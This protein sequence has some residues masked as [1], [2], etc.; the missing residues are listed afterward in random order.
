MFGG[1][2]NHDASDARDLRRHDRHDDR[3][4]QRS[5]TAWNV[6]ADRAERAHE[7][8]AARAVGVAIVDIGRHLARVKLGDTL[9]CEPQAGGNVRRHEFGRALGR[10]DIAAQ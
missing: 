6:R 4:R 10:G 5:G 3:R 8:R 9:A 2:R 7:Q 1:R